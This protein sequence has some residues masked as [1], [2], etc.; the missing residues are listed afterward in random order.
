M[1]DLT[2]GAL[3]VAV[4]GGLIVY[5]I[6]PEVRTLIQRV[7]RDSP[8]NRWRVQ[9]RVEDEAGRLLS[10]FQ[11][12]ANGNL[13]HTISIDKAARRAGIDDPGPAVALLKERELVVGTEA[14][15][16]PVYVRLTPKG[17]RADDNAV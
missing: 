10:E 1:P 7:W 16:R 17:L 4:I 14:G 5:M 6:G 15:T 13:D 12:R 8:V 3:L 11:R 9:R 2:I